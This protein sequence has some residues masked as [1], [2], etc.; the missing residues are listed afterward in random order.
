MSLNG[1]EDFNLNSILITVVIA[2]CIGSWAMNICLLRKLN[3]QEGRGQEETEKVQFVLKRVELKLESQ[4][5]AI[6]MF[7]SS[8]K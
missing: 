4:L 8:A 1:F 7:L 3:I 2:F 6:G 5:D